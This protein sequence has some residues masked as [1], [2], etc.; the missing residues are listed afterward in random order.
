MK[1]LSVIAFAALMMAACTQERNIDSA[2]PGL[3]TLTASHVSTRSAL[4][5]SEGETPSYN[6]LWDAPD[7]ILVG[8]AGSELATFTSKN[9]S[10]AAEATFTGK[11]PEGSGNLFGLYPATSGNT[12][13]SD[14]TF[15]V[16]F[17]NEQTAVAGSYDPE[18]FP[19]VAVSSSKNLSFQNICGLLALKVGYDDV[20]KIELSD[21]VVNNDD[22]P[23]PQPSAPTRYAA[24][25]ALPGGDMT[26]KIQDGEPVVTEFSSFIGSIVLNVPKG[27][28]TFSMDETYYLAVY[29]LSFAKGA[30]F[31]LTHQGGKTER[32]T[33]EGKQAVERN[34]VHAVPVLCVEPAVPVSSIT[35][36][37]TSIELTVGGDD[38]T[39]QYAISPDD[40]SDKSVTWSSSN[41]K[42]A[43]VSNGVITP[44]AEGTCTVTISATDDSG[45]TA[46]INVTVIEPK[47]TYTVT[48]YPIIKR[49][50]STEEEVGL[51]SLKPGQENA[52][53]EGDIVTVIIKQLDDGC[54]VTRFFY[55]EE[56]ND[57]AVYLPVDENTSE[58][59]FTMPAN[60]V[61]VFAR[62]E[63][64]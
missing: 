8:Y 44:V 26:V 54:I 7:K 43:T 36:T 61:F 3:T 62:A 64:H 59:S 39:V 30:S 21:A 19:S 49:V 16:A 17:K 20:T 53:K 58:Y 29:P 52:F 47:P 55:K 14:G 1:K 48:L 57:E 42:V 6:I 12:A 22:L 33:F 18:A 37:E 63:A 9:E 13:N 38:Y 31:V 51:L 27:K 15:T 10:P 23:T 5:A 4:E 40:A 24:M 46:S 56:D 41:K 45:V 35:P 60:N 25:V 32:I 28:E 2:V 34:K 11:L 50:G